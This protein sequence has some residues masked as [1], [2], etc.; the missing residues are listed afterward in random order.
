[1]TGIA[2]SVNT[3]N[4]KKEASAGVCDL[5]MTIFQLGLLVVSTGGAV[6]SFMTSILYKKMRSK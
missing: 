2:T 3:R 6:G 1:M 4:Y 5:S